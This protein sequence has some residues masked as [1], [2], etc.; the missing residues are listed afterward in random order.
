MKFLTFTFLTCLLSSSLWAQDYQTISDEGQTEVQNTSEIIKSHLRQAISQN[1][2]REALKHRIF[3][4]PEAYDTTAIQAEWDEVIAELKAGL[5]CRGCQRS[6]REYGPGFEAHAAQNGGTEPA[7]QSAFDKA[8]S[9]YS[10]K[11]NIAK[12]VSDA[13]ALA[14]KERADH[15]WTASSLSKHLHNKIQLA[16]DFQLKVYFSI[17]QNAKEVIFKNLSDLLLAQDLKVIETP[18]DDDNYKE[19]TYKRYTTTEK[20]DSSLVSL[21]DKRTEILKIAESKKSSSLTKINEIRILARQTGEDEVP[22]ASITEQTFAY[23]PLRD[24]YLAVRMAERME[25]ILSPAT[26]MLYKKVKTEGQ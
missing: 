15:V 20:M 2:K 1:S 9:T 18:V 17:K 12:D 3:M 25:N 10:S 11:Y 26:L 6:K 19:Y 14:K 7:S 22:S 4:N 8:N 16:Y 23:T 5:F 21:N 24:V 13:Y